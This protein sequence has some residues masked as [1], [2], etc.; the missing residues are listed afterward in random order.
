MNITSAELYRWRNA[1]DGVDVLLILG[2]KRAGLKEERR[3]LAQVRNEIEEA[4]FKAILEE[5]R[6]VPSPERDL[7]A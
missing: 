7:G 3:A 4:Y 5:T 1:I 2:T 6:N